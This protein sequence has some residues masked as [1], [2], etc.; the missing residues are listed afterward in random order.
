MKNWQFSGLQEVVLRQQVLRNG[1]GRMRAENCGFLA[2]HTSERLGSQADY[3]CPSALDSAPF[4]FAQ[5]G[6]LR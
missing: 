3:T 2:W 1:D 4:S 6:L 5:T